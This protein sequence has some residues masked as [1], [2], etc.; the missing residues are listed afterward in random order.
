MQYKNYYDILGVDKN[1]SSDEIKKI[2]RKLAKQYH[3]DAN[4]GNKQAEEKFKDINEAY[5]VL[6]DE[7]KR[8]KYD[9]LG[10][11]M[12]FR[13]F[14]PSQYK[15]YRTETRSDSSPFSDFFNVFFGKNAINLDDIFSGLGF[16]TT[17]RTY[18]Q[19]EGE[20]DTRKSVFSDSADIETEMSI[21]IE[22]AFL[23]GDKKLSLRQDD[24]VYIVKVPAGIRD[25][26]KIRLAE[27]GH[28]GANGH[29]GDLYIKIKIKED[30][31]FKI[32]GSDMIVSLLLA[33][34]EA[35]LGCQVK[36]KAIDGVLSIMVPAGIQSGQRLR[37][38]GKGYRSAGGGRGD[39]FAE[40]AIV[41]P[42][43]MSGEERR[44]FEELRMISKF[45]PREQ[46]Q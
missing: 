4:P 22:E 29:R 31:Y 9:M 16:G 25:G 13:N 2:Y 6:G 5:E 34:W 42:R 7:E 40:V 39:L 37:L 30:S 14:D 46:K 35:A 44:L 45:N 43:T 26:E 36:I 12:N 38:A 20:F 1:A 15:N 17:S 33:P 32:E 41:V 27:L 11:N 8:K 10:N 24:K 23:G 28:V 18:T 19:R 21:T 3:P